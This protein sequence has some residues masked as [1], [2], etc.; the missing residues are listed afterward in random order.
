VTDIHVFT[1]YLVRN[2]SVHTLQITFG[3]PLER[4]ISECCTGKLWM[5]NLK[6]VRNLMNKM[7]GQNAEIF[8][9]KSGGIL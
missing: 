4:P 2:V 8:N 9:F 5:L 3:F 1:V 7:R 6:F